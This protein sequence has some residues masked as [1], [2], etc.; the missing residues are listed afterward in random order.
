MPT[1]TPTPAK[2][3]KQDLL[4]GRAKEADLDAELFDN[5]QILA[6]RLNKFFEAYSGP[7]RI[8]SGYRPL[9]A[10]AAAGG[11]KQSKH[12][13]CAAADIADADCKVWDYCLRNLELA[14]TLG[15]W[16]EDKRWTPTWVHLQIQAPKSG[17]RIFVP[18]ASPAPAPNIWDGKY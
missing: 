12:M 3:T 13:I 9:E 2:I 11:A 16:F 6:D 14:A 7:L 1:N 8:T 18:N 5:L 17:K 10:N 4:M 15:L